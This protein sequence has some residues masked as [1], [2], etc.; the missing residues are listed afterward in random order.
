MPVSPVV[1][2]QFHGE[3]TPVSKGTRRGVLS[4]AKEDF[5]QDIKTYFKD[6]SLIDVLSEYRH[7]WPDDK[8]LLRSFKVRKAI[9]LKEI[10]PME[11]VNMDELKKL[12]IATA[13]VKLKD[14]GVVKK[15]TDPESTYYGLYYFSPSHGKT[16]KLEWVD[17]ET[18]KND[19][20]IIQKQS[21]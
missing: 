14:L 13:S 7:R 5:L 17:Y 12:K 16:M 6:I 15:S 9:K 2:Y 11:Q 21:P 3:A 8:K 10:I 20:E 19:I 18:M 1:N 4:K